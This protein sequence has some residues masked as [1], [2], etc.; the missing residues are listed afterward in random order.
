MNRWKYSPGR[1]NSRW[2]RLWACFLLFGLAGG[3]SV[4]SVVSQVP[5]AQ[6]QAVP[7]AVRRAQTLLNQGL[8][9]DAIAA[10]NKPYAAIPTR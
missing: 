6:A 4:G 10:F 1:S 5:A 2:Q 3:L 8:V 9:N 7:A